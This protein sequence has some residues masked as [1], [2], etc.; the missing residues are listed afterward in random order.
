M[1]SWGQ[2]A[3]IVAAQTNQTEIVNLLIQNGAD[4]N[5]MDE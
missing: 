5:A 4:L 1:S 2:T 3:L